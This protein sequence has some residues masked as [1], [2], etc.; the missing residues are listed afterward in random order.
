[1]IPFRPVHD[2]AEVK[3]ININP[4]I[5]V[6]DRATID[7]RSNSPASTKSLVKVTDVPVGSG[8]GGKLT[9]GLRSRP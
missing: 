8:F 1:M 5:I 4:L 9:S 6:A 2:I 7:E 3:S